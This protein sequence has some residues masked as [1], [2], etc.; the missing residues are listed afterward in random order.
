MGKRAKARARVIATMRESE[1]QGMTV[2]VV[3]SFDCLKNYLIH[4]I[5]TTMFECSVDAIMIFRFEIH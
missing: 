2:I 3:I 1:S 4:Y 5:S